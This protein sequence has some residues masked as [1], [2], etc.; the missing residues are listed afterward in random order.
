MRLEFIK[1]THGLVRPKGS[2]IDG[3]DAH[4]KWNK[5]VFII[6]MWSRQILSSNNRREYREFMRTRDDLKF[7]S[8]LESGSEKEYSRKQIGRMLSARD[9]WPSQAT[10]L[11]RVVELMAYGR[12]LEKYKVQEY[13]LPIYRE[14]KLAGLKVMANLV[15]TDKL[16]SHETVWIGRSWKS[17]VALLDRV[18]NEAIRRRRNSPAEGETA[19]GCILIALEKHPALKEY[20]KRAFETR[21]DEVA[22]RTEHVGVFTGKTIPFA[23]MTADERNVL[24]RDFVKRGL[25]DSGAYF[26]HME[27]IAVPIE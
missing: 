13:A 21:Y 26:I 8:F 24:V 18:I 11:V 4:G 15:Y 25:I 10:P 9:F 1:D 17:T 22:K 6:P 19:Q 2:G 20:A 14:C 7:S 23:G 16:N 3:K 27:R 5:R 12:E